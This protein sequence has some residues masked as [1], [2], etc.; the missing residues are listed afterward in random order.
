MVGPH[1]IGGQNFGPIK[2]AP[3]VK[4]SLDK[5]IDV[6][7]RLIGGGGARIYRVDELRFN[8]ESLTPEMYR[9][10]RYYDRW[11]FAI[12]HLLIDKDVLTHKEIRKKITDIK[13]GG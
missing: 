12:Y 3:E 9:N 8:I 4:T 11:L 10:L 7:Q 6:L 13:A 2:F 5:R 1:D